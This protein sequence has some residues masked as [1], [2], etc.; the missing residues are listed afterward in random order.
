MEQWYQVTDPS[1]LD[2]SS[3]TPVCTFKGGIAVYDPD[4]SGE[5]QSVCTGLQAN[6]HGTPTYSP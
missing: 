1:S 4:N 6:G 5:G 3:Q 2:P